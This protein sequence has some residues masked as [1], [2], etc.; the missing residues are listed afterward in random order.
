MKL[1]QIQIKHIANLAKLELTEEE[2]ERYTGQLSNVLNYIDQL[3]EVDTT[4]VEPTAQV[5][6]LENIFREDVVKEW[7]ADEVKM[8]LEQMPEMEDRQVKVKRVLD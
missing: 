2:L 1:N 4:G 3:K 8:A 5:T 6:G 7:D